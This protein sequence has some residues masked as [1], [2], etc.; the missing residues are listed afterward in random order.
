MSDTLVRAY[1]ILMFLEYVPPRL[2]MK[3]CHS[4]QRRSREAIPSSIHLS[5]WPRTSY[6]RRLPSVALLAIVAEMTEMT[7]CMLSCQNTRCRRPT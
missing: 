1:D 7:E 5:G 2:S 4:L 6:E 3:I